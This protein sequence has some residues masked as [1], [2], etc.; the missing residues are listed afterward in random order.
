MMNTA[1]LQESIMLD[2]SKY[3]RR[4]SRW[5]RCSVN[6]CPLALPEVR[7]YQKIDASDPE[8]TCLENLKHRLRIVQEA[9]AQDGVDLGDGLTDRE[10]KGVEAGTATV[11]SII[12]GF[13]RKADNLRAKVAAM[14]DGSQKARQTAQTGAGEEEIPADAPETH[15]DQESS[16]EGL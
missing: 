5:D 7:Q 14:I 2:E 16:T 11:E 10:R 8:R 12:A 15:P 9:K 4:C 6:K 1:A 3:S 13:E